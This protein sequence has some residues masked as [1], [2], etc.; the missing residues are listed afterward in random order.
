MQTPYMCIPSI[1]PA[2]LSL[3]LHFEAIGNDLKHLVYASLRTTPVI[4][5]RDSLATLVLL[6]ATTGKSSSLGLFYQYFS[7]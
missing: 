6:E 3:Q 2:T 4:S 7:R 5:E 1:S